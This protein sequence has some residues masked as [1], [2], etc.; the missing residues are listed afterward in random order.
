MPTNLVETLEPQNLEKIDEF[1]VNDDSG[2]DSD[3]YSKGSDFNANSGEEFD[4]WISFIF[5]KSI[6]WFFFKKPKILF[7]DFFPFSLSLKVVSAT[8]VLVCPSHFKH[9]FCSRKNQILEFYIFKF[10]DVIKCLSIKQEI[11]FTK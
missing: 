7:I 11:H 6:T 3:N 8:F 9:F 10:H 1:N 5:K 4:D 2:W